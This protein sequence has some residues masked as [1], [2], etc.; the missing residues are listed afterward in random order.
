MSAATEQMPGHDLTVV[1]PPR[2]RLEFGLR[3]LWAYRELL[4]FLVWRDVKTRYKQTALGMAWALLQPVTQMIVFTLIFGGLANIPSEGVPYPLFVFTGL[5][6]WL[7]FAAA[8][9]AAGG[10][11]VGSTSLITKVYFPRLII[12]LTAVLT[13]VVDFLFASTVLAA[14]FTYY[15]EWPSWHI[16]ALPGFL[17]LAVVC[18]AGAGLWISAATVRYRDA[19]FALPFLIQ[20]WFFLT[21]VVYPVSLVPEPWRGIVSLN[22]MTAPID[23]F[24]WALLDRAA[25]DTTVLLVGI[26]SVL[27]LFI[28][29]L[30]VFNRVER[31]LADLI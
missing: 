7:Y 1:E 16:V 4:G 24:R 20:T 6:P 21:P 28:S 23:G 31:T 14:L 27:L 13:P 19:R 30:F 22:P 26:G 11:L 10:S 3:D 17:L 2:K 15:G 5:L 25:P 8:L 9:T 29:G 18:A 12:P